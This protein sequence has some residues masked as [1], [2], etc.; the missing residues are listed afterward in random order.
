MEALKGETSDDAVM[1]GEQGPDQAGPDPWKTLSL[2]PVCIPGEMLLKRDF[3]RRDPS[4]KAI[5]SDTTPA[6]D[7]TSAERFRTC[8]NYVLTNSPVDLLTADDVEGY[9]PLRAWLASYMSERGV[10]CE[11]E[12]ILIVDSYMEAMSLLCR[13][14]VRP[15]Q[16]VLIVNPYVASNMS[17][18]FCTGAR[19]HRVPVNEL[20]ID[21]DAL[22]KT[23]AETKPRFLCVTPVFHDPTGAVMAPEVRK[24]ILECAERHNFLVIENGYTDEFCYSGRLI[25]SL[26][27]QDTRGR[28][29]Y[30]GSFG[31]FLFPELQV[32]WMVA[33]E[34]AMKA[35]VPVKHCMD[36]RT[37]TVL[38]AACYEFCRWGY[39]D[40]HMVRMRKV[41]SRRRD[42]MAD[43][44]KQHMP[45]GV[46][47][48]IS[49][50]GPVVWLTLPPGLDSWLLYD[51]A[52]QEGVH[53]GPGP[54]FY[55]PANMGRSSIRLAYSSAPEHEIAEGVRILGGIIADE[56][57]SLEVRK[58]QPA[59][60]Q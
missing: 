7:A 15:G 45:K 9:A 42:T 54:V 55:L 43:S 38:Q 16:T 11:K 10:P 41:Y 13:A 6:F 12:N 48:H 39:L 47:W 49:E 25:P 36:L 19:I 3:N 56:M 32:G 46:V 29:V 26:K 5:L 40:N 24:G 28:V 14:V 53:R 52:K 30:V 1:D 23:A 8:L 17:F 34:S 60:G 58:K 59:A 33:S 21:L 50:G 18:L 35:L 51:K 37:S 4:K 57:R 2:C 27:S 20:G 31:K 22:D 44:F